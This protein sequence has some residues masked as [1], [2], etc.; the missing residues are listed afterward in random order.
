M[1]LPEDFFL[2]PEQEEKDDLRR[3]I[4]MD[5]VWAAREEKLKVTS[6]WPSK[7]GGHYRK[8]HH[9]TS[10]HIASVPHYEEHMAAVAE[11][12]RARQYTK[13]DHATHGSLGFALHNLCE[14][15]KR[16]AL[17]ARDSTR[18]QPDD[19]DIKEEHKYQSRSFLAQG[20]N[21]FFRAIAPK[22]FFRA[23]KAFGIS[24]ESFVRE[25]EQQDEGYYQSGDFY[26]SAVSGLCLK[27]IAAEEAAFI[28]S[29][30][31][32]YC[33]HISD[34]PLSLLPRWLAIAEV[35]RPND[36]GGTFLVTNHVFHTID[37]IQN[38][39]DIKGSL[40]RKHG[41]GERIGSAF[42]MPP[43][44]HD[45]N[46]LGQLVR[47]RYVSDATLR[48]VFK[49]EGSSMV[50]HDEERIAMTVALRHDTVWL[51][52]MGLYNY[53]VLVGVHTAGPEDD[54]RMMMHEQ[55]RSSIFGWEDAR[56]D[57]YHVAIV[58]LMLRWDA[59]AKVRFK[60]Q[61]ARRA[62]EGAEGR[63]ASVL[64]PEQYALRLREL[65]WESF[66]PFGVGV[67]HP[68]FLQRRGRTFRRALRE[69]DH[70]TALEEEEAVAAALEEEIDEDELN[71]AKEAAW[72][73]Q[74]RKMDRAIAGMVPDG[75]EDSGD[76]SD[77]TRDEG[78]LRDK[79][80]QEFEA[81]PER[82]G[83]GLAIGSAHG[84]DAAVVTRVMPQRPAAR[85][86]KVQAGDI[87]EAPPP[88]PSY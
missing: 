76:G 81:N 53:S 7:G 18:T 57:R 33:A 8:D 48:E 31:P 2:D 37:D 73:A 49:K 45:P 9:R 14:G 87:I 78:S 11:A 59:Q 20:Y 3:K 83:L 30:L 63:Q 32:E 27:K 23:R 62:L 50:L 70:I 22:W 80:E 4:I 51:A 16:S 72:K 38:V 10:H 84:G 88:P 64:P 47:P 13:V 39:F 79:A 52:R 25:L 42:P 58:G 85:S 26:F 35:T 36:T 66:I 65:I 1:N 75:A 5:E 68:K 86:G 69:R 6:S 41:N 54:H 46:H 44:A 43:F 29:V 17:M 82:P 67:D 56:E 24:H 77:D 55:G 71:A 15:L 21:H 34:H 61:E 74:K 60:V 40:M 28:L 19:E 12:I